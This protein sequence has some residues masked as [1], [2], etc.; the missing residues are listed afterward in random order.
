MDKQ[1]QI[2]EMSTANLVQN[3]TF[4]FLSLILATFIILAISGILGAFRSGR[5]EKTYDYVEVEMRMDLIDYNSKEFELWSERS[6][7][8]IVIRKEL[9]YHEQSNSFIE[10]EYQYYKGY[11]TNY[12]WQSYWF[13]TDTILNS[14]IVMLFYITLTNYL[15]SRNKLKHDEYLYLRDELNDI[16]LVKNDV[17]SS[18][19]EPFMERWNYSRK[20]NQHISNVKFKLSKLE[21]ETDYQ[22]KKDF[23]IIDENYNSKFVIPEKELTKEQELYLNSK[24]ELE[25]QLTDGFIN[26]NVRFSKVKYFKEIYPSFVTTGKN[27]IVN[28]TDEYSSI[29]SDTSKRTEDFSRKGLLGL[30][31]TAA[32]SMVLSFSLFSAQEGWLL[33]IYSIFLRLLPLTL[34]V[35]LSFMYTNSHFEQQLVP[36]LKYRLNIINMYLTEK[37]E[38]RPRIIVEKEETNNE[39]NL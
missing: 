24:K 33:L 36:T 8:L 1:K 32:V 6:K 17:P 2:K 27:A 13:Y 35:F 34:Q 38:P 37:N 30:V 7:E 16:V 39:N 19:F 10:V 31:A 29:K 15:I 3:Q 25:L 12:F 5:F 11:Y 9:E 26:N 18:T 23:Y 20:V 14:L 21:K 28:S 4:H 22:I